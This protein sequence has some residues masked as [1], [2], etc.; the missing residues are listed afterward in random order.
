MGNSSVI[1]FTLIMT[2]IVAFILALLVMGLKPVHTENESV[3]NK[4]GILSAVSEQLG[5]DIN[6]MSNK[7]VQDLFGSQMTVQALN[8]KEKSSLT[9][10]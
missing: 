7:E 6:V 9:I 4:K 1:K 10:K 3:Y 8:V 2:V 5:K